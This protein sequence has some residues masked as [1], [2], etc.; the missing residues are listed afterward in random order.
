MELLRC[1]SALFTVKVLAP[2]WAELGNGTVPCFRDRGFSACGLGVG[3]TVNMGRS[4]MGFPLGFSLGTSAA[5][6]E[7][8]TVSH[9][10]REDHGLERRRN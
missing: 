7:E 10:G 6:K 4:G 9:D 3:S 2:P 1:R 5:R 8:T